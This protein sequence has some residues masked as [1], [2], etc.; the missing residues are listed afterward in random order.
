MQSFSLCIDTIRHLDCFHI[1]AVVLN[2]VMKRVVC[3]FFKNNGWG[4]GCVCMLE[5]VEAKKWNF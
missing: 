2:N 3:I 4:G 1:L 5:S